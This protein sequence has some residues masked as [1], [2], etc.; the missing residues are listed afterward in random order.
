MNNVHVKERGEKMNHSVTSNEL[1][2]Q[3]AKRIVKREGIEKLNI[4]AIAKECG[5]SIGAVYNYFPSKADIIFA[6]VED[7]WKNVFHSQNC[8]I[9]TNSS[10]PELFG[11]VYQ[12]LFQNIKQFEQEFLSQMVELTGEEK[13]KGK[14]IEEIYFK[15]MKEG[16]L[17]SLDTDTEIKE[18]IF[19][20]TFTKEKFWGFVF[21]QMMWMLKSGQEDYKFFQEILKRILGK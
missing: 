2:L 11:E 12:N 19:N 5:I 20:E 9:K 6:M 15:H 10:F 1:L 21:S 17:K 14:N 4:R 3:A 18:E 8:D 13:R 16:F 7:F